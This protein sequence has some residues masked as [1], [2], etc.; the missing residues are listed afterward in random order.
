METFKQTKP[1]RP[2]VTIITSTYNA[3]ELLP[4]TIESICSQSYEN[5]EWILID[6]A[7]VDGTVELLKQYESIIT[8][9]KSEPDKGIYDAWNKAISFAKG[10]WITFIGAGDCY[11]PS[12]I[13]NYINAIEA[14]LIKPDFVCSQVEFVD[15]K[16]NR[17]RVKGLPFEWK[18]FNK[19]MTIA[20]V[21]AF[22]HRSLFE[23]YGLFKIS[24]V[25]AADYEFLMRCG[26][27][28][29][30]LFINMIT[31]DMLVGG[32]SSGY[33]NIFETN[34]IQR[35]Y[36]T[37]YILAKYRLWIACLKRFV[38]PYVRGY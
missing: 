13:E 35:H 15:R 32:V 19:Y 10:E 6:C 21:G 24:Y 31:V 1:Y 3:A 28:L 36:G 27:N 18:A 26:K 4:K 33:K 34:L 22:H 25:T 14:S 38:R 2:L 37:N 16:G 23:K 20:H 11:K 12:A 5:I 17:L 8:Y 29:K 9:W 30:P 7:S